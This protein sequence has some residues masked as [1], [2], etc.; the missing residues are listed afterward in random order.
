[1]PETLPTIFAAYDQLDTP[2]ASIAIVRRGEVIAQAAFGMAD[3]AYGR[4]VTPHTSFRLASVTKQLTAMLVLLLVEQQR[5]TLDASIGRWLPELPGYAHAVTVHQL[6]THTAGLADYE[7]CFA[8][9]RTQQICDAEVPGMLPTD[10]VLGQYFTPGASFRYSNTGY[11]LLALIT[12]RICGIRFA[13][14][15]HER[16]F[17]R[18]GMRAVAYE[19]AGPPIPERAYGH[20]WDAGEW[21]RADQSITSATLGDGGV[22]ASAHDMAIWLAALDEGAIGLPETRRKAFTPWAATTNRQ[23]YGYGWFITAHEGHPLLHHDGTT[24]GFRNA[25]I[26][27][28]DQRTSAI[29]L[30]NRSHPHPLDLA[31]SAIASL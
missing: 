18:L 16:I 22:Y 1:M 24:T 5:L 3:L 31:L 30:T 14:L 4:A 21:Q 17:A 2:G 28:P 29:V 12:E 10:A 8:P 15:L 7:E 19:A 25:I 9:T 13:T 11:I 23:H 20:S 6:L 26:R 27:L